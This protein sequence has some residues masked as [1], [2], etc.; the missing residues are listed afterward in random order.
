[1]MFYVANGVEEIS[2]SGTS[3]LNRT[4]ASA[5]EKI[6]T[7]LLKNGVVPEQVYIYILY[8]YTV[9]LHAYLTKCVCT[10]AQTVKHAVLLTH[11][12]ATV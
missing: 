1:M 6:V 2:S 9:L 4:E 11:A 10:F 5:V 3:Y 8:R 12:L 7:H